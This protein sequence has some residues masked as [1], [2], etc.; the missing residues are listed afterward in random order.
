MY[1]NLPSMADDSGL[2][3]HALDNQPGVY[4]AD[5]AETETGRD[6]KKAIIN[7]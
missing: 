1:S 4:T 3:V 2:E 6:F 5:W 7:Y